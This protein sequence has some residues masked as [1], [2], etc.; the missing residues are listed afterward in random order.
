MAFHILLANIIGKIEASTTKS[1]LSN[2]PYR[3]SIRVEGNLG[4]IM[5]TINI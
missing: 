4:S 5:R 1:I 3:S 2:M